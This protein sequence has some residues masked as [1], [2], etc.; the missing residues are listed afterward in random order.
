MSVSIITFANLGQKKNHRTAGILPVIRIFSKKKKLVQVICQINKN[1][2]IPGV[3]SATPFFIR[4]VVRAVEIVFHISLRRVHQNLLDYFAHIK[5]RQADIHLFHAGESFTRTFR[6]SRKFGAITVSIATISDLEKNQEIEDEEMK[7]LGIRDYETNAKQALKRCP[8]YKRFDY[9]IAY[10]DFVRKSYIEKG[11]PAEKIF[12][13]YSDIPI[14]PIPLKKQNPSFKIL[15]LAYISPRKG[16]HYLLEAWKDLQLPDAQLV[17]V[18]GYGRIPEQLKKQY[19]VAID[20]DPRITRIGRTKDPSKYYEDASLFVFPSLYEGNPKVVMEAMTYEVPVITTDHAQSIIED[21]KSGLVVPIRDVEALKEKIRFCYNNRD[22]ADKIGRAGR[23]A[24]E[25]KKPFGEAV[26]EIYQ[27]IL[28][29]E[30][31][32]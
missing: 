30:H 17:I 9:I 18:G 6:R 13:A 21:G 23:K 8:D 20:E 15:Y 19:E 31:N 16:L 11:Y 27:D 1:S 24:M 7:L 22:L 29:R 5:L 4:Y 10:S 14:P 2:N 32:V 25:N 12:T 28:K 26:F 3:V